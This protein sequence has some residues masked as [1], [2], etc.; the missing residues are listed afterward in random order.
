MYLKWTS[1]FI[2]FLG[3]QE[4]N[5]E[6]VLAHLVLRVMA[7]LQA[8]S[9]FV[10]IQDNQNSIVTAGCFGIPEPV[11]EVLTQRFQLSDQLPI[12][13]SLRL[14]KIVLVNSLPDWPSEYP[15]LV[16][17]P[18][19]TNDA[20]FISFPIE[21][22]GTPVAVGAVFFSSKVFLNDEVILFIESIANLLSMYLSSPA[23]HPDRKHDFSPEDIIGT[24][25]E[26]GLPLSQ[27]Q[28]LILRMISEGRTNNAIGEILQYS[29]STIRQ[30]TIRI[31]SKLG[32]D[33][34]SEAAELYR[35]QRLLALEPIKEVIA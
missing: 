22:C 23:Y 31:F 27:R 20:A 14:R 26:R 16:A 3:D 11:A 17:A 29:E 7:P 1:E 5:L 21:K 28:D 18:Y 8:T 34:R 4:H 2:K 25:S 35:I 13:D 19:P 9:A 12:T 15:I 30:E 24:R 32:C 6:E 33:G 10:S